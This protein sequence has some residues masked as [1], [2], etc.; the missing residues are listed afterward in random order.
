[1]THGT[2]RKT[3]SMEKQTPR[4]PEETS[5]SRWIR[6]LGATSLVIAMGALLLL[7]VQNGY[8][9]DGGFQGGGKNFNNPYAPPA[10]GSQFF[11]DDE[12][13]DFEM[14]DSNG[15]PPP[16]GESG[17]T[18]EISA[19]ADAGRRGTVDV[20]GAKSGVISGKNTQPLR[21][22]PEG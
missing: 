11:E 2:L 12:A 6:F 15:Y 19:A 22:D 8:P 17:Y 18:G 14:D 1:M 20:E 4:K 3:D 5:D 10:G 7:I 16:G 13:G 21:V 9:A